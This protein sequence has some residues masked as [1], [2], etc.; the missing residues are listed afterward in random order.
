[1]V[2]SLPFRAKQEPDQLGGK[3]VLLIGSGDMVHVGRH[4][5][6]AA[7]QLG[8]QA[9]LVDTSGAYQAGP[10][11]RRVN[12]W[13]RGRRPS[14]IEEFSGEI[15]GQARE[16]APEYVITTGLSPLTEGCVQSLARSG[17][18][19]INFLTDDPWNRVHYA[20]W[21][22]RA[23]RYYQWVFTPRR[24]NQQQLERFCQGRVSYLPFAYSEDLHFPETAVRADETERLASD[25][26]FAG[27]ADRDRIP[28]ISALLRQ[29]Y[30]VALYG[31]LWQRYHATRSYTRGHADPHTLRTAA[32]CTKIALCLVRKANRDGHAMRSFE[33]SAM[34]V[35]ML[36]ERTAEHVDFFGEEGEAVRYFSSPEDLIHQVDALLN[37]PEERKRLAEAAWRRITASGHTYADRLSQMLATVRTT[38]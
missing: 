36:V 19:T 33:M 26:L 15:L 22:M 31:G 9:Q 24:A 23:L 1:M 3:R 5:L 25:I 13:L 10:V 21:F 2:A 16:F 32:A 11:K 30:R 37:Q 29:G 28:W 18:A 4:L 6:V 27:G 7:K 17:A 34:Q 38:R 14:R 20:P 35:C 12:W 8:C